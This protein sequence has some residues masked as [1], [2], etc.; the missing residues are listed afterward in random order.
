VAAAHLR[1]TG[2]PGVISGDANLL[3]E[4][5]EKL[6]WKHDSWRT[7]QRVLDAIDRTN[8]G[9]LIKKFSSLYRR[10]RCFWLPEECRPNNAVRV[11]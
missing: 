4:I 6:G 10:R 5:A 7:E 8:R 1:D 9:E 11:K 2:N 3:H